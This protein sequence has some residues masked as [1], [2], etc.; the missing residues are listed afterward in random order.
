MAHAV[1]H[2]VARPAFETKRQVARHLDLALLA[3]RG[4]GSA[5]FF[6]HVERARSSV[7]DVDVSGPRARGALS[8]WQRHRAEE[9][10][11]AS[12]DTRPS[13]D[14]V[15]A[16]C[17]LSRGH[18]ARAFRS[19]FGLPP[20]A[21]LRSMR[22]ERARRLI[23]ESGRTLSEIAAATGFSDQSHLSRTFKRA[24]GKNPADYRR[25]CASEVAAG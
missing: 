10:L 13:L 7:V 22:I 12:M 2:P 17:G 19:T 5:A 11:V 3:A 23:R 21:W 4:T 14:A 8:P 16:A 1:G 25:A 6:E 18:F 20:R 24:T 9:L 15:A